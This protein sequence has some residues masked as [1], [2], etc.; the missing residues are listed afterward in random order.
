M[1]FLKGFGIGLIIFVALNF[2]FSMIIAAIAG[3]IGNYFIALADWTTIFSVLF[4]SITITPH[5]II[6]G[7]PF[8]A[9]SYTGLVTAIANNEMALILSLI[10]SLASPI[11]AAILAGRFAGGKRFAF[12]AWFLIAIIC[13]AL[14]L[15]PNLVILAG[16]GA[17]M[18][19]Y[20]LQTHFIL[21]PGIINGVFYAP[22]GML[23]SEAEF[24]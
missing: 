14:L 23:V 7:G 5:L 9:I 12:L 19:T 21:F 16:T 13:A 11:I 2:V 8:G 20:L 18:E 15:I 3:I 1:G 10:F 17:T 6:F 24:Y 4:G 22:F